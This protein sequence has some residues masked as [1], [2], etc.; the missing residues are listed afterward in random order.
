M[1]PKGTLPISANFEPQ[2]AAPFD[3]RLRVQTYAELLLQNT[4]TAKDG[5]IYVYEGMPVYVYGDEPDVNGLYI[6]KDLNY[7]IGSSWEKSSNSVL[8]QDSG[9]N[10]T[11]DYDQASTYYAKDVVRANNG[12]AYYCKNNNTGEGISDI[13]PGVTSGWSTYWS[14]YVMRGAPGEAGKDGVNGTNG[15]DGKTPTVGINGNWFIGN[16]DTGVKAQGNDGKDGKDGVD[17]VA[18]INYTGSWL[19]FTHYTNSDENGNADVVNASDGNSYYCYVEDAYNIE[20][21][22]TADWQDY[23]HLFVMKGPKGD[24]GEKGEKGDQGEKGEGNISDVSL[25]LGTVVMWAGAA[26]NIPVGFSLCDGSNVSGYGLV[27]DLRSRFVVGYDPTKPQTPV[28]ALNQTLN[29]GAIGNIGGANSVKLT[30]GQSGL[31]A[32]KHNIL[33]SSD[34]TGNIGRL[35]DDSSTHKNDITTK[36]TEDVAAQDAQYAHENR[37]AYYVLA[38]IIKTAYTAD[39]TG[40][41]AYDVYVQT[42]TDDP[43]K[44]KQQ[45]LDS[46]KGEKGDAGVSGIDYLGDYNGTVTY[47]QR[48]CVRSTIDGNAYYCKV[49]N[50]TAKEPS[51]NPTEWALFVMKGAPGETGPIGPAGEN[52][53][54]GIDGK[55]VEFQ[56]SSTHVQWRYVGDPTWT[57]LIPLSDITGDSST[58][59][60][61][62][63]IVVNLSSG[64][65]LGKYTTGQTIPCAGLTFEQALRDIAIEFIQADT[66]LIAT[67]TIPFN[68]TSATVAIN[69]GYTLRTT[70]STVKSQTLQF[71]RGTSGS[72]T[73]IAVSS[74]TNHVVTT[75]SGTYNADVYQYQYIFVETY[76]GT[77]YT[78]TATAQVTPQSY[79]APS[80]QLTTEALREIGNLTWNM[81]KS[82]TKN[83]V[84]TTISTWQLFVQMNNGNKTAVGSATGIATTPSMSIANA[85][86]INGVAITTGNG[87]PM[88]LI[89]AT[90]VKLYL[91]IIDNIQSTD[92]HVLTIPLEYKK[93]YGT[94]ST[95]LTAAEIRTLT[96]VSNG[97]NSHVWNANGLGNYHYVCVPAAKSLVSIVTSNNETL[98]SNFVSGLTTINVPDAGRNNRSYK[99]YKYITGT[100]FNVTITATTN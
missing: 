51:A 61:Q 74:G 3:S 5:N 41:T 99:V 33:A 77:D 46:L 15:A 49:D 7:Y 26:N 50:T 75:L 20:P 23:W 62:Q 1:R 76:N 98:T 38:Y 21:T 43:V 48:D 4:W 57:N 63:N 60:L 42:T 59:I 34:F 86:T 52:G 100:N 10:F 88:N 32:H 79:V 29:Y 66:T 90:D 84:N 87:Y 78:R 82:I 37:P 72:W 24:T 18:K 91:R 67:S 58:A 9:V 36:T 73:T 85:G 8:F 65:T 17:V 64:K 22:V 94:K 28:E 80:A 69:Y 92:A 11:G 53:Q 45:W 27:P 70:G 6:L 30:A 16:N 81:S 68:A 31:P 19:P 14:L 56:K 35:G 47:M 12:N 89:D 55:Q 71:R 97:S 54:A 40:K 39:Y 44:T 25:Q 83:S 13:E 95:D 96:M 2:I 93:F